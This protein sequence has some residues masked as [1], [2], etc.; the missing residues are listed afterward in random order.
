MEERGRLEASVVVPVLGEETISGKGD[1]SLLGGW[2]PS[3][4]DLR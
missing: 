3:D 2:S 4:A 1:F